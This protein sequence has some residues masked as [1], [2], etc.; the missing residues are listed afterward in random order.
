[1]T[2]KN[3]LMT[4]AIAVSFMTLQATAYDHHGDDKA[5]AMKKMEHGKKMAGKDHGKKMMAKCAKM[6]D[7]EKTKCMKH[8]KEKA[9]KHKAKH[10]EKKKDH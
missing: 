8:A 4:S 9:M 1:M 5:K 6:A 10:A 7:E 2:L 3:I